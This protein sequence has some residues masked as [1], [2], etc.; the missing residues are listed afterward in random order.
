MLPHCAIILLFEPFADITD[1]NDQ[2]G[3]RILTAAQAIVMIVQ[4]LA[5]A[6]GNGMAQ[7]SQIMHSSASV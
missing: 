5:S 3:R 4:Q 1:S 6:V 7:L 2:P